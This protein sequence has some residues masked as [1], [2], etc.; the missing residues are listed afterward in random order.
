MAS[1]VSDTDRI[2]VQLSEKDIPRAWLSGHGP[3]RC[4]E[5]ELKH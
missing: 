2:D 5:V 1:K 3:S 4:H